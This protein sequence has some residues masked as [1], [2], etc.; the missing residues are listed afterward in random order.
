MLLLADALLGTAAVGAC[1]DDGTDTAETGADD[2]ASTAAASTSAGTGQGTAEAGTAAE[3][4]ATADDGAC[5]ELPQ[6]HVVNGTGNGV[7]EI[8]MIAC[9]MSEQ[10][11]FPVPPGGLPDGGELTIALPGAGCWILGYTGEGCFGD[12]P[13]MVEA[14]CGETVEWALTV[15]NHVCAGF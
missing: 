8:T 13:G 4:A 6:L 2:G 5:T 7:E 11:A 15:E 1:G 14:A 10:N 12:P 9:D 3:T